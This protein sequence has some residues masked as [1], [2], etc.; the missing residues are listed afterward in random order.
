MTRKLVQSFFKHKFKLGDIVRWRGN[1]DS[2]VWGY[3]V[4]SEVQYRNFHDYEDEDYKEVIYQVQYD[5]NN[6]L[7]EYL[8][9]DKLTFIGHDKNYVKQFRKGNGD[10]DD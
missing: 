8:T 4:I 2:S 6:T 9:E 10:A 5:H 3:G 1:S 7:D